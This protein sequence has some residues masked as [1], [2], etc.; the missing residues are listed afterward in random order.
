MLYG[1]DRDGDEN[2]H[3]YRVDLT[4]GDI[5]DLTPFEGVQAQIQETSPKFPDELLVSLND[6][7]PQFHNIYRINI[8]TGERELTQQNDSFAGYITDEDFQVRFASRLTPD[9][10][11]EFLKPAPEGEWQPYLKIDMEDGLTTSPVGFDKSG[12]V[13]YLVDSRGRETA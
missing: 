11:S 8:V 7:N 6:L 2:W 9:G 13:I 1:Q 4:S 12:R 3:L 10:G 5:K